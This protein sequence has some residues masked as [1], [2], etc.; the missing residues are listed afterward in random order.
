MEV[1]DLELEVGAV[2]S[3]IWGCLNWRLYFLW[4]ESNVSGKQNI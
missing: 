4:F 2:V 3:L 1:D